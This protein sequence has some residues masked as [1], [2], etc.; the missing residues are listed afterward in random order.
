MFRLELSHPQDLQ[1]ITKRKYTNLY[2]TL[3]KTEVS[4]SSQ[5]SNKYHVTSLWKHLS[6]DIS[7]LNNSTQIV[8]YFLF[9]RTCTTLEWL[10]TSRNIYVQLAV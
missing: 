10:N 1:D 3:L 4:I 9:I 8:A 5:L 6:T 2:V 7:V